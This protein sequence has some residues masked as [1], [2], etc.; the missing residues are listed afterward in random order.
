MNHLKRV[1][2]FFFFSSL[3]MK[4]HKHLLAHFVNLLVPFMSFLKCL[5]WY[6]RGLLHE[7]K[8]SF[9]FSWR[10]HNLEILHH[11]KIKMT[12]KMLNKQKQKKL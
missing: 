5:L 12:E 10:I 7:H 1:N 8:V 9:R 6:F 2:L 11:H 4:L 3:T